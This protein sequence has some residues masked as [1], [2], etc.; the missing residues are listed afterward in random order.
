MVNAYTGGTEGLDIQNAYFKSFG[1]LTHKTRYLDAFSGV[2][3]RDQAGFKAT[4]T[5][6]G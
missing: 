2:D 1:N 3:L 6:Q 4:T 5:T